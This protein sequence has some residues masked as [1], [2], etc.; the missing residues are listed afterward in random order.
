[1]DDLVSQLIAGEIIEPIS[2]AVT[3]NQVIRIDLLQGRKY[4]SDVVIV[5]RR[6][7]VETADDGTA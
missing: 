4:L 6:N 5:E 7:D 3:G 1:M 2:G